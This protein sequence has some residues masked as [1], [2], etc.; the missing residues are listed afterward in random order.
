MKEAQLG[1]CLINISGRSYKFIPDNWF[2]KT[3]IMLN[4]K[5]INALVNAKSDNFF[6]KTILQNVLLLCNSKK[7]LSKQLE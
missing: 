7:T 6:Y 4:K 5:N 3:I 1:S 2:N